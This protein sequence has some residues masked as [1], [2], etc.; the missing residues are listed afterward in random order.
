MQIMIKY[1][2]DTQYTVNPN[3]L[4]ADQYA[5]ELCPESHIIAFLMYA[6]GI[7]RLF[8]KELVLEFLYR[9][10][11]ILKEYDV[12]EDYYK[13]DLIFS[14]HDES[15]KYCINLTDLTEHLGM[16][17]SRSSQDAIDRKTWRKQINNY[18]QKARTF[19]LLNGTF[20][21]EKISVEENRSKIDTNTPKLT[22]AEYS[23]LAHSFATSIIKSIG[24]IPFLLLEFKLRNKNV[25]PEKDEVKLEENRPISYNFNAI[26]KDTLVLIYEEIFGPKYSH[27]EDFWDAITEEE[28]TFKDLVYLAYLWANHY[29]TVHKIK[30]GRKTE[31]YAEVNKKIVLDSYIN[32]KLYNCSL[33]P[34]TLEVKLFSAVHQYVMNQSN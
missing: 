7:A 3:K 29:V 15:E 12:I 27:V 25:V 4:F 28:S 8:S 32:C 30:R 33:K 21:P 1:K 9:V 17:V 23:K 22:K 6:C 14:F 34:S 20:I 16:E 24:E 5:G 26:P 10:A 31:F 11:I 19:S 2:I 13:N 18:W